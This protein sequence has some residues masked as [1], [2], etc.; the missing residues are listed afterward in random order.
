MFML[1]MKKIKG[2]MIINP[3]A[4]NLFINSMLF[5]IKSIVLLLTDLNI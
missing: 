1:K 3:P 4:R 2:T 5:C